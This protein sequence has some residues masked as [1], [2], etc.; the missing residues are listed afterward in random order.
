MKDRAKDP[1]WR[2]AISKRRIASLQAGEESSQAIRCTY[3][4]QG[5]PIRCDSKLEYV[6][7][8]WFEKNHTVSSIQRCPEVITYTDETGV[9][10]R[11]L[12]DFYIE[13]EEGPF[14]VECKMW[15]HPRQN[16]FWRG[17]NES[18][19]KKRVLLEKRARVLGATPLWFTIEDHRS[20]YYSIPSQPLRDQTANREVVG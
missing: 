17:Y 12:P 8:V 6:C 4:F 7:L 10:R 3:D 20:L 13:T 11:Y 1:A 18:Q 5:T 19:G 2:E 15:A 14:L 9:S 16:A